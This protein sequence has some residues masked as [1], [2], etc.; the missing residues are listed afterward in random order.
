MAGN[1]SEHSTM[2][3]TM[4]HSVIHPGDVTAHHRAERSG[5]EYRHLTAREWNEFLAHFKPRR[6]GRVHASRDLGRDRQSGK[7]L[8]YLPTD[9]ADGPSLVHPDPRQR[10][11]SLAC[12]LSRWRSGRAR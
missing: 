9:G 8:G 1:V 3:T 12:G 5:G 2:D 10:K 4:G 7:P 11:A 6:A